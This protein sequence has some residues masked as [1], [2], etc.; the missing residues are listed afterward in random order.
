[1]ATFPNITLYILY[2]SIHEKAIFDWARIISSEL[3]FQ[4]GNIR[5]IKVLCIFIFY[6][7]HDLLSHFQR[8]TLGQKG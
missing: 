1:M 3:S 7:I 8:P 2:F 5:K 6:F 4:L